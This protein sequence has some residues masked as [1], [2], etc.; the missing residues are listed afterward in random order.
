MSW[1]PEVITVGTAWFRSG[2]EV[3]SHARQMHPNST[4]LTALT[5][6]EEAVADAAYLQGICLALSDEPFHLQDSLTVQGEPR[7]RP[8][9]YLFCTNFCS[10]R[11]TFSFLVFL[12][13]S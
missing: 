11:S 5:L 10:T 6:D 4:L 13:L 8:I 1:G 12:P 2:L 3:L 9:S 7:P